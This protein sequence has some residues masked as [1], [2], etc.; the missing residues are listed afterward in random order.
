MFL[1][2]NLAKSNQTNGILKLIKATWVF[3]IFL[4]SAELMAQ[5]SFLKVDDAF[6]INE[7]SKLTKDT[8]QITWQVEPGYYLYQKRFWLKDE[9]SNKLNFSIRSKGVTKDDPNFGKVTVH[10]DAAKIQFKLKEEALTDN[11][12]IMLGYQGCADA[13]LCYPPQKKQLRISDFE[14]N[15]INQQLEETENSLN[16]VNQE[17]YV[18]QHQ[19]LDDP[20]K[21]QTLLNDTKLTWLLIGFFVLG[22]GLSFTPCVLPMMPILAGIITRQ[23]DSLSTKQ[24]G[25]LALS[26]VLGMSFS[27][28]MAGVL[29]GLFGAE[30]NLQAKLQTPWVLI[31]MAALFAVLALSMF[32]AFDLKLPSFISQRL[33]TKQDN[34][35]E[36]NT[37]I[38]FSRYMN[39]GLMGAIAALVVS[40]CITAPLA[41]VL[42]YISST[43]DAVLGASALFVLSLGMGVPLI[44]LGIGGGKFLPKSG[45]WMIEV[46]TFFGIVLAGMAIFLLSRILAD[47]ISMLLIC[48]L[49]TFYL[50][51]LLHLVLGKETNLVKHFMLTIIFF[52]SL[53]VVSLYVSI[54]AGQ[55]TPV[56]PLA[57]LANKDVS[58]NIISVDNET[59]K[60]FTRYTDVEAMEQDIANNAG[61]PYMIDLYADWCASCQ[62]L[63]KDVFHKESIMSL[64]GQVN[65]YQLDIT[66]NTDIHSSYMASNALFG[67]PSMMFFDSKSREVARFQGVP[68]L[69]RVIS[70]LQKAQL[71]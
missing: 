17:P 1:D 46:K 2:S 53:Y 24:G 59:P 64:K 12:I 42:L 14:N 5:T 58:N 32:G 16:L 50:I 60:L 35:N 18:N 52:I 29:V 43:G 26:Y 63:E 3:L 37:S 44:L 25:G 28:S 27:Y 70:F 6:K 4:L 34:L 11:A 54:L 20:D 65:F 31:P 39:V 62:D 49:I 66:D 23:G 10:Y 57:F 51:H 48:I 38:N 21:I 13:G 9:E 33:N 55:N 45:I 19:D 61:T 68:S 47:N 69:E 30:L 67:P 71:K 56:T 41:G 40:P 7:L 8:Y 22:L 15:T 36:K